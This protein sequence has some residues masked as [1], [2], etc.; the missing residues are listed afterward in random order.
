MKTTMTILAILSASMVNAQTF[1]WAKQTGGTGIDHIS[2][3]ATDAQGNVY[4]CGTFEGTVDFDPGSGTAN[5]TAAGNK[6]MFI[7]KLTASGNFEWA[8]Q[9]GSAS[10]NGAEDPYGIAVGMNGSIYITG[11]FNN[12]ID[13]DAGPGVFNLSTAPIATGCPAHPDVFILKLNPSGDFTWAGQIGGFAFDYAHGLALGANDDIYICGDVGRANVVDGNGN[14]V[15][16]NLIDFDPTAGTYYYTASQTPYNVVEAGYVL[17]LDSSGNFNWVSTFAGPS[18]FGEGCSARGNVFAR[19]VAVDNSGNVYCTGDFAGSFVDFDPGPASFILSATTNNSYVLKLNND[20]TFAWVKQFGGSQCFSRD[21]AVDNNSNVLTTG[22]FTNTVDFNPGSGTNNL[23]APGSPGTPNAFVCKLDASG[24]YVWA[25][26][27]GGNSNDDGRSID[28]DAAGNVYTTGLFNGPG[29]YNPGSAKFNLSP[30]GGYDCYISKLNPSGNFVWAVRLGGTL[31]D[32]GN[33]L[34]VDA[35]GNVYTVGTFEGTVDFNPAAQTYNL[36]SLGAGDAF[37][38]KMSQS[39][40]RL[41]ATAN[42]GNTV[43]Q[44]Y[45]NPAKDKISIATIATIEDIEILDAQGRSVYKSQ[46]PLLEEGI[47]NID[48]SNLHSGIYLV[49]ILSGQQLSTHKLIISKQ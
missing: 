4:A 29:D 7:S 1:D 16:P 25:K 44:I 14:Y 34:D 3:I 9:I 32:R 42:Y 47:M 33:A 45:P 17:K 13:F 49:R 2:S 23:K 19:S 36:T 39:A 38:H 12:E 8:K 37:I 11:F 31:N 10:S 46:E 41:G 6:D 43:I 40:L 30:A 27:L 24:S 48:L 20:G 35:S 5:M 26:Q 22:Y 18:G 28:L 15:A 21:I